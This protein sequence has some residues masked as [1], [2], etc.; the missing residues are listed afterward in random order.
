MSRTTHLLSLARS[1][2]AS[3]IR[4]PG[5]PQLSDA[6]EK[7]ITRTFPASSTSTTAAGGVTTER[8]LGPS[9]EK[10][11]ERMIASLER[12]KAND[13]LRQYPLSDL[14]VRPAHDPLYYKRILDGVAR[15]QRGE[16]RSWWR[17]FF[18]VKGE[19]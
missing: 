16:G 3:P 19:A 7:I 18:Q 6:L 9:E 8:V 13:S 2:P 17:R 10:A 15:S 1:L 11:M 5:T 4:A 14:T 12:I